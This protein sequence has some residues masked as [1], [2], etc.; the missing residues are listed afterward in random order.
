MYTEII[1]ADEIVTDGGLV[2]AVVI[3][4]LMSAPIGT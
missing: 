3:K 1:Y 2:V 4:P